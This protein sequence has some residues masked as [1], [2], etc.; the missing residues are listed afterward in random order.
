MDILNFQIYLENSE[1]VGTFDI[2][3][4]QIGAQGVYQF[5]LKVFAISR[6]RQ[7]SDHTFIVYKYRLS[8]Q[9]FTQNSGL[10]IQTSIEVNCVNCISI[11][12]AAKSYKI[13]DSDEEEELEEVF[14]E[15]EIAKPEKTGPV[16][17]V[18]DS[19]SEFKSE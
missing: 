7:V 12:I 19:D 14:H 15:N 9:H 2:F 5:R 13:D 8:W 4:G 10:A 6:G 1:S 18:E 16:Q 3:L 17:V 11:S